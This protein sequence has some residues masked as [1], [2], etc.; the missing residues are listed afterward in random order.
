MKKRFFVLLLAFVFI[1]ALLGG[2]LAAD[3]SEQPTDPY[4]IEVAYVYPV[5][6]GTD[7]WKALD[8]PEKKLE[9]CH[10]PVEQLRCMTTD[11]L[12]ETVLNYPLL[13]NIYAYNSIEIGIRSVSAYFPGLDEL[14]SRSDAASA[15]AAYAATLQQRSA[16]GDST[17]TALY[18]ESLSNYLLEISASEEELIPLLS[19]VTLYTPRGSAISADL[20]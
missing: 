7:E 17:I 12:L 4:T 11:A 10:V 20:E 19:G 15:F 5:R 13:V 3:S 6:P 18:L 16:A 1:T 2:T 14:F 8:T 9:A